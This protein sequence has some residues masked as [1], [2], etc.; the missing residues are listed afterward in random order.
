MNIMQSIDHETTILETIEDDIRTC[1]CMMLSFNEHTESDVRDV[2]LTASEKNSQLDA[3]KLTLYDTI[4]QKTTDDIQAGVAHIK[5]M[6]R[7]WNN[8]RHP[9]SKMRHSIIDFFCHF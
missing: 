9:L 4:E 1:E 6:S 5:D 3:A 7:E 2:I 8:I